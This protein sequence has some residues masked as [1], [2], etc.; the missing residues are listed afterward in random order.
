MFFKQSSC[1][2]SYFIPYE[3]IGCALHHLNSFGDG[4]T[5]ADTRMMA[6]EHYRS[7]IKA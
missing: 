4:M 2:F 3:Q 5:G 7:R 1:K 6:I